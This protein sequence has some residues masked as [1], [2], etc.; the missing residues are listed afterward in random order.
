[1]SG[2]D[3][4]AEV[5]ARPF[6]LVESLR[7][8]CGYE[9]SFKLQPG[10]VLANRYLLGIETRLAPAETF[11]HA[12]RQL[13]MPA[14]LFAEFV[15]GLPRANLV[16]LGFEADENGGALYKVYLEWWDDA[17][18]RRRQHGD[19]TAQVCHRGFKWAHDD[20]GRHV[21]TDYRWLPGLDPAAIVERIE[22]VYAGVAGALGGDVVRALVDLATRTTDELV[23][24]E[25]S[26]A[27]NARCSFDLNLYR[28]GLSVD[29]AID[30][31]R[32]MAERLAVPADRFARLEALVSG[33]ALGHVSGGLG[34]D[35]R[36]YLTVYYEH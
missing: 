24:I 18:R 33:K 13:G 14:D 20:P 36:E 35:R 2:I 26:E 28:A 34:R 22:Q 1:M 30:P 4:L 21:I 7:L 6:R 19:S 15:D 3:A 32:A 23:Y 31:V 10:A 11:L 8:P 17:R 27:G 12:A 25:V 5:A 9:R 16:F 29:Q